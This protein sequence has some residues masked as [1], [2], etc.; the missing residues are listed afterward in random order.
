MLFDSIRIPL[1]QGHCVALNALPLARLVVLAGLVPLVQ[2]TGHARSPLRLHAP[3]PSLP[4]THPLSPSHLLNLQ[5]ATLF[6]VIT[7]QKVFR[8]GTFKTSQDQKVGCLNVQLGTAVRVV[9]VWVWG[10]CKAVA[11]A[12]CRVR[13]LVCAC[14]CSSMQS[15]RCSLRSNDGLLFPLDKSF[16]FI[17]KPATYIR[18]AVRSGYQCA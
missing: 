2:V 13:V 7:K 5:L 16:F 6:K 14:L 12:G 11:E 4:P 15:V 1:Q 9:R 17:H 18:F 10:L 3:P 8:P